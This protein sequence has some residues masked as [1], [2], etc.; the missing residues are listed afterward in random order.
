MKIFEENGRIRLQLM[1]IITKEWLFNFTIDKRQFNELRMHIIEHLEKF[2][3]YPKNKPD[4]IQYSN[5]IT[6]S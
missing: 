5:K 2:E 6:L 4:D 3:L 1:N